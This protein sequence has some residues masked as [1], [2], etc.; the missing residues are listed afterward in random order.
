MPGESVREDADEEK[1]LYS[2][3][4]DALLE[5]RII[6]EFE[7]MLGE[8]KTKSV[9]DDNIEPGASAFF[10]GLMPRRLLAGYELRWAGQ[11]VGLLLAKGLSSIYK[12]DDIE[13]YD[14]MKEFLGGRIWNVVE[15]R[16]EVK[17]QYKGAGD[18]LCLTARSAGSG[19]DYRL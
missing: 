2:K 8:I 17:G 12:L 19:A 18:K 15:G 4:N 14:I 10:G 9:S 3:D 16:G 1:A 11:T 7:T 13:L 6:R 5:L